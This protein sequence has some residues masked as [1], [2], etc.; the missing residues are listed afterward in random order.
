MYASSV[1]SAIVGV[2]TVSWR[3]RATCGHVKHPLKRRPGAHAFG[4]ISF[5]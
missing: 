4:P 2:K 1:D 3:F 5:V